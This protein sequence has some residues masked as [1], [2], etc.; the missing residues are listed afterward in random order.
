MLFPQTVIALKDEC[1]LCQYHSTGTFC[2]VQGE[3][4][5]FLKLLL[6]VTHSLT[7]HGVLPAALSADLTSA[8][9]LSGSARGRWVQ[10]NHRPWGPRAPIGAVLGGQGELARLHPSKAPELSL[11][12]KQAQ[13]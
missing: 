3:V 9:R 12:I 13:T 6:L 8:T 11:P 1:C 10:G 2:K 7:T 5:E 4:K